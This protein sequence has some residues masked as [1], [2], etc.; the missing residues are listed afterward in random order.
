VLIQAEVRNVGRE[1]AEEV[2]AEFFWDRNRDTVCAPEERLGEPAALGRLEPDECR[3]V[4]LEWR[5][6]PS[7]VLYIGVMVACAGDLN[8]NNNS[9]AAELVV[10]FRRGALVVNEI[11][12]SPLRGDG[13]WVEL[14]NRSDTGV[15]LE[16]WLFSDADVR[17]RRMVSKVP[18]TVP[19]RGFVLLAEDSSLARSGQLPPSCPLVVLPSWPALSASGDAVVVYDPQ[20]TVIDSVAYDQSWGGDSGISLERIN[21]EL[22]S[23]LKS[24]WSSC[25]ERN[26]ATPGRAN[27]ILTTV[28]PPR[29]TLSVSPSP[30]SPDG[31]GRDDFAVISF[32]LPMTTAAVNI[33]IYDVTGRLIRF[34]ASNQPTGATNAVIWDGR[35]DRGQQARLGVYIVYLEALNASAGIVETARTT[36]VVAGRL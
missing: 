20:G 28:V 8:A 27:S 26:G 32:A 17:K 5:D 29:T 10:G 12:Y 11:M 21:P 22:P 16:K 35:D 15:S 7:G 13:E 4:V 36:V 18:L 2:R 1:P 3:S 25:V 31:D 24:N 14:Y 23:Q 9:A 30:F 19:A 33:K 6:P 34:L